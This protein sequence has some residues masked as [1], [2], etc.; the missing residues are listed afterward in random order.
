MA[1]C[2]NDLAKELI[3]YRTSARMLRMALSTFASTKFNPHK[4]RMLFETA[5]R[6]FD[7]YVAGHVA[8]QSRLI[9]AG[10]PNSKV[11]H[12]SDFRTAIG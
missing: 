1:I 11:T 3:Q 8:R 12:S 2:G 6:D 5:A 9:R 7:R 4:G 10:V